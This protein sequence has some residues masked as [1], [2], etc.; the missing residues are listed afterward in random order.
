MC[1][2]I[3][4]VVCS[5]T[6][7]AGRIEVAAGVGWLGS[8]SYARVDAD[9]T[10]FGGVMRPLFSTRSRLEPSVGPAV[11]VGVALTPA[12]QIESAFVFNSAR[13]STRVTADA[14]SAANVTVSEPVA[15]YLFEAGASVRLARWRAGR[16]V[17]FA[18]AGGGYLRHVNDGS[19]LVESG[20][21]I[22]AGGGLRYFLKT[23]GRGS[24]RAAG[25]R[26]D[27]RATLMKGGVALDQSRRVVPVV[28]ASF[29]V[30]F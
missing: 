30:R 26:A 3:P 29:F 5:Q 17:P 11:R 13:L 14:E 19:T 7:D 28:G 2:L 24:I 27:V 25:L 10:A 8:A 20:T 18:S 6:V 15:Q 21:T 16:L 22:Y 9:E 1:C 4:R 12:V 23:G